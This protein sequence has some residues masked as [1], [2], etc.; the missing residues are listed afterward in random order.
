MLKVR[1][2][3]YYKVQDGQ[4]LKEI[5]CAF[6]VSAYKIAQINELKEDIYA[7]QILKIPL[8]RG[9]LY[10]V[11]EGDSKTLLCGSEENYE[12]WNGTKVFYI[13]M[14]VVIGVHKK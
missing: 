8:E 5:S 10:T 12:N 7:G 9:N 3:N 4:T 13:G 14:Q 11:K 2:P 1:I 6:G